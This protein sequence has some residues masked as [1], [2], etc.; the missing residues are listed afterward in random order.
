MITCCPSGRIKLGF[1]ASEL[2]ST[3]PTMTPW[4]VAIEDA[5]SGAFGLLDASWILVRASG[6]TS[7]LLEFVLHNCC[8]SAAAAGI[9]DFRTREEGTV[10][11]V[12]AA[13][14]MMMVP[15]G[16]TSLTPCV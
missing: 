15:S 6:S 7:G 8:P 10:V 13:S 4:P 16:T 14:P 1:P 11:V 3:F 2:A 9:A 12:D 5:S